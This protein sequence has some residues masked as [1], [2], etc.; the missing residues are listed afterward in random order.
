MKALS[1]KIMS[2][3]KLCRTLRNNAWEEQD[4]KKSQEL[5]KEQQLHWEKFNFMKEL[6][7]AI[8]KKGE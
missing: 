1:D 4:Y 7:K 2:E 5:R 3:C 6:N 8:E